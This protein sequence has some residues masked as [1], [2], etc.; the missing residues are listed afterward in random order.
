[1]FPFVLPEN[2]RKALFLGKHLGTWG[3]N[4]LNK[5]DLKWKRRLEH[6]RF[7][8]KNSKSL[9]LVLWF[10]NLSLWFSCLLY[11]SSHQFP[12]SIYLLKVNNRKNRTRCEIC[13]KLTIK[14]PE[15]RQWGRSG[16][17]IVNFEQASLWCLTHSWGWI[18][19]FNSL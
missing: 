4:G 9:N 5:K 14:T 15:R 10:L 17:F 11:L 16:V 8:S 19:I 18:K 12:A 7:Y 3:R 2:I 6:V 13:S 1:M